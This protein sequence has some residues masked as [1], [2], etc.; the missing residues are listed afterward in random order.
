MKALH[1]LL[2][3]I[4]I[5]SLSS[6]FGQ[7]SGVEK[8]A[9]RYFDL[10]IEYEYED[11]LKARIYADSAV[12]WAQKTK[13]DRILGAAYRL[14]GWYFHDRSQLGPAIK[15]YYSSLACMRRAG[16]KQGVADAYGNLGNAFYDKRDLD[17]S[18]EM[19]LLSLKINEEILRTSKDPKA[20]SAA[21][22][23]RSSAIH[24]T[25]D[26]YGE[27]EMY[28]E[29]FKYAYES[30]AYDIKAKD[31]IGIAISYNTIATLY[32]ETDKTDSAEYYFKKAINIYERKNQPYEYGNALLEYA[33][34]DGANLTKKQRSEMTRKVLQI[35]RNMRDLG[36]EASSLIAIGDY[37]FD[38]L[39]TDSLSEI[40]ERAYM[41]I[42]KEDLQD[43]SQKY[44]QVYSKYNSRIGDFKQAFFALENYLE[45]KAIA[46]E[47]QHT[48]DLIAGGIRYQL[49][50]EFHQNSLAQQNEFTQER[51][52][53]LEEISEIQNIV[54]LS[55]IGFLFLIGFLT[56]YVS[57]NRR[58][59]RHN[60][61]LVEKNQL[62]QEQK[63]LVDEK[64]KSI[65]DSINYAK[66]LQTAI[67]PTPEQINA[68][69]PDSFLFF[70]PK[71]VV[72]GDFYWFEV[73]EDWCFLAVADCTGHGVPGALVS[74]VC[75]NALNGAVNEF[76]LLRPKE[77]LGKT[78]ELVVETF[79]KSGDQVADGMDISLIA[80]HRTRKE[81]VFSGA[82]NGL[83]IVRE[84]AEF[85]PQNP[86][87]RILE[88]GEHVLLEFRGDKQPI[89]LYEEMHAFSEV[90]IPIKNGD[91]IYLMSDGFADQFGGALGKKFKYVALKELILSHCT[92]SLEDQKSEIHN[93]FFA[94]K[95]DLD[96]VDDVCI[97]GLRY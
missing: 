33:T 59:K 96:Q 20:L 88:K 15:N 14:R 72:S 70:Q 89:G 41:I 27:I 28:D 63:N 90:T 55:V 19:Q 44:F 24:N 1:I 81:V 64:N 31:S 76:G 29:A 3:T 78:R 52:K 32:K 74:V 79:A 65:S 62:V 87:V 91:Q 53:Y 93:A 38:E 17:K 61:I 4:S 46:D 73:K 80:L 84:K 11:T 54:Y 48:Q 49:E 40:L 35:R 26:I 42:Q 7:S 8:K 85:S 75:S 71:D 16:D 94:W 56:Y 58:R 68:Y 6:V 5:G 18:L 10:F 82:H 69:L 9:K 50:A 47:R 60:A 23:G 86:E 21:S 13:D 45:L 39:S 36:T 92:K 97:V 95:K 25:G 34:L 77:I 37:F 51:N 67:L 2:F 57:S 43:L 30:M 12:Y 22:E 66:R 83:W